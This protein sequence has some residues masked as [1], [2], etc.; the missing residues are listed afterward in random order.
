MNR[1]HLILS[2]AG[3]GLAV[4]G[5]AVP[6]GFAA[7]P[8]DDE[9]AYANFGLATEFLLQDFYAKAADSK[10]FSGG[11][12]R[13]LARGG[14]S[15]S[16]HATAL[17][18][19][20]TDA[21][22]TA[23]AIDDFEF[24]WPNDAFKTKKSATAAGLTIVESLLGVYLSAAGAI[25]IPSYRVLY[26]TMAANVAQQAA[27]LSWE[28]DSRVVGVSFPPSLDVEAASAAIDAYLG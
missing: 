8:T 10:L 14:R 26:A 20:L 4:S 22:Q 21:G 2:A 13:Q 7:P 3:A 1:R 24:A 23:A 25:S 11:A 5:L 15:A 9:L 27:A 18:K 6:A 16:E 12:V 19:L 28:S 17:T